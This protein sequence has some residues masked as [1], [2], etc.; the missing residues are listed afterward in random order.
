MAK[1][2]KYFREFISNS[3]LIGVAGLV[4]VGGVADSNSLF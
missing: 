3:A 2:K 4:G 1:G